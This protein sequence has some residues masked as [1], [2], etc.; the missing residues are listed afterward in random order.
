M[1][2]R[3]SIL[4]RKVICGG[5]DNGWSARLM[6]SAWRSSHTPRS[7]RCT[8]ACL[9]QISAT[10]E[11][12]NTHQPIAIELPFLLTPVLHLLN[13]IIRVHQIWRP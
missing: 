3:M 12:P 2:V 10:T 7:C 4:R 13:T 9:S 11:R 1:Y 5:A 8:K 6:T